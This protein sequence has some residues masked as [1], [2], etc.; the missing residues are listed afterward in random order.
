MTGAKKSPKHSN[1][2]K[3]PGYPAYTFVTI[4]RNP[5]EEKK[6]IAKVLRGARELLREREDQLRLFDRW[7]REQPR[8]RA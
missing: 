1:L 2:Q 4:K 3:I 8:T 7:A 6:F 5:K